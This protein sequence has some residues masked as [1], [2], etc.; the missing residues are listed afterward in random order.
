[1]WSERTHSLQVVHE[2]QATEAGAS[3]CFHILAQTWEQ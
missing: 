3:A 2:D 1:M